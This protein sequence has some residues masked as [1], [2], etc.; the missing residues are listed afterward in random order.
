MVTL[1]SAD[2]ALKTLYLGVVADQLNTNVNPVLARIKQTSQDVW[3]KEIQKVAPFGLNGGV[4]AGTEDGELPTAAGNNYAK[5]VLP[6]KNLY[7]T[8]NISD[9]AIRASS[10]N[11][12]AFVNLLNAE[13]EGLLKASSFN[14]GRMLFGDG[15]GK[16]ATVIGDDGDTIFV[17]SIKNIMEGMVVDIRD[18]SGNVIASG[19]GRRILSINRADKQVT[20]SGTL[21]SAIAENQVLTVQGSYNNEITGFGKIFSDT[22]SLYGLDRAENKWMIPY[23][24]SSVGAISEV[25]L[26]T[27]I[28]YLDEVAGSS[29]D[30]IVCSSGVKRAYQ[31]HLASFKRNID[32][33]E[34]A[35]GYRALSYNGIPLISDRFCGAGDMY[36]LNTADFNLHQLCDWQWLEGEDGRVIK[37]INGRPVYTAT[38][39]KY[40]DMICNRPIGQAKLSG[41]TEK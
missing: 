34:L 32:V 23:M 35:G 13:M 20:L 22:G 9:K 11:A 14:F 31:D 36:L 12:G 28:D 8:L 10:S 17:D 37:Q 19:G 33:M 18:T 6:L 25:G 24:K 27:A 15:S 40:A 4:G 16:I 1:Q 7:G 39:V 3:G 30:F 38:L 41:I 5:F 29:V 26:Q 2:N 21:P